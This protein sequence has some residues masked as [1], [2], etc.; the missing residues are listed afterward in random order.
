MLARSGLLASRVP[1][2][3]SSSSAPSRLLH[4]S[5]SVLASTPSPPPSSSS[6]SSPSSSSHSSSSSSS[7]SS[8][9]GDDDDAN[10]WFGGEAP[11]Y[12]GDELPGGGSRLYSRC[13]AWSMGLCA[14]LYWA[15]MSF[16]EQTH[17]QVWAKEY[18]LNKERFKVPD[19]AD[20]FAAQRKQKQQER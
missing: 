11:G 16:K 4:R 2:L 9:H 19:K 13:F 6:H 1:T 14:V 20:P 15:A 18:V 8:H 5:A 7:A 17:P 10:G 3:S 12:K